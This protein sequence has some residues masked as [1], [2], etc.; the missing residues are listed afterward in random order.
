VPVVRKS[1]NWHNSY[2]RKLLIVPL[3]VMVMVV[4]VLLCA[5]HTNRIP[6]QGLKCDSGGRGAVVRG[7]HEQNPD[8]GI[9]MDWHVYLPLVQKPECERPTPTMPRATPTGEWGIH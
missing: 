6:T 2:S 8:S 9:E 3:M 5:A 1:A 4:V 7:P